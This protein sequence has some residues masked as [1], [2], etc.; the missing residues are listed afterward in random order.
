MS[1]KVQITTVSD[2]DE[3][4]DAHEV[5]FALDGVAFA[6]DLTEEQ[7]RV[8]RDVLEPYT[9][10]GRRVGKSGKKKAVDKVKTSVKRAWL[11]EQGHTHI[12]DVGRLPKD[13]EARYDEAHAS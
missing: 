8:L 7:H 1:Q 13:L 4:P 6:I 2:L 3:A 5:S 11:R 10:N 9:V 12:G